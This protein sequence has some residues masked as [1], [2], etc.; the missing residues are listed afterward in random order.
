MRNIVWKV[1]LVGVLALGIFAGF[2]GSRQVAR[3][4]EMQPQTFFVQAG[5][6]GPGNVEVLAFAP[7]SLQVHRGDTVTWAINSFHNVHFSEGPNELVLMQDVNGQ[8]MPVINPAVGLPTIENGA[9]Y[10]GG[11][12]NSGLPAGPD[13]PKTFSLVMDLEPG[14]Y[15]YI[16][17]VHPGMAGVINVVADDQAIPTPA[18]VAV[19]GATELLGAIGAGT[20]AMLQLETTEA[21]ATDTGVTVQAGNGGTGR[22]TVNQF[23][24]FSATI[25]AG[26][27]VTWT[28]PEDSVEPHTVSWPA[29]RGQDVAPIAVEGGAPILALGPTLLPMT[30]SGA[31]VAAGESFSSGLFNPGQSFSLTFTEPGVYPYVCN[32]HPGMNGVIVVEPGA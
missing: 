20:G 11:D 16:C 2:A 22:T 12:A 21:Q 32:I 5:G 28:I 17:D 25:Q 15:S 3:A 8:Q 27:S 23:F 10:S 29:V 18:E 1:G 4:Q 30:Q 7:Q 24:P 6:L 31:E 9:T 19:Q 13:A 14:T 26:Q